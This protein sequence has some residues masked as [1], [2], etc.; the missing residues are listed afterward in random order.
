M[1]QGGWVYVDNQFW[2]SDHLH[3][4]VCKHELLKLGCTRP[5]E[6]FAMKSAAKTIKPLR[7]AKN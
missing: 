6:P 1:P 5:L 2:L 7:P 4:R 3:P